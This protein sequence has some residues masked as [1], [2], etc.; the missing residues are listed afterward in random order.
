MSR[1]K[2]ELKH[3]KSSKPQ[4]QRKRKL[5]YQRCWYQRRSH[6]GLNHECCLR[7]LAL[8]RLDQ[9]KARLLANRRPILNWATWCGPCVKEIPHFIEL[10]EKYADRGL[11]VLGVSVDRKGINVVESF[12]ERHKV[13]YQILMADAQVRRDYGGIRSIPTTFVI[14]KE[15]KIQ[16]HYVGYRNKDVFEDDINALLVSEESLIADLKSDEPSAQLDAMEGLIA[17]ESFPDSEVFLRFCRDVAESASQ[18]LAMAAGIHKVVVR[19]LSHTKLSEEDLIFL[20]DLPSPR[21]LEFD[22]EPITDAAMAYLGKLSSLQ[23][24]SLRYTKITD[25]GLARLQNL[26]SLHTL[27]LEGTKITDHGLIYLKNLS[28]LKILYV[29]G[30]QVTD[31]GLFHLRNLTGLERFCAHNMHVTDLGLSHLKNLRR[32]KY[33]C[34]HD[35][36]VSDSGLEYLKDMTALETLL[37]HNTQVTDEGLI[38]LEDLS[39][40]QRLT[41]AGTTVTRKGVDRLR[42]ILPSCNISGPRPPK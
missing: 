2:R 15:G 34:L 12:V 18:D 19:Y 31:G 30:T 39:L 13:N 28:A 7:G 22:R 11:V 29:G 6:P 26:T 37:L 10:Y 24:L 27:R 5:L 38:F 16:R 25:T 9:R 14:D 36:K 1:L 17:R 40:L 41:L 8:R 32:L 33:L 21:S 3:L 35:T 23:S 4:S 20:K 42:Q